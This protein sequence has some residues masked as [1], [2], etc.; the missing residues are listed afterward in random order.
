[1]SVPETAARLAG[2]NLWSSAP[3]DVAG[4]LDAAL[5]IPLR[6]RD[7]EDGRHFS[8]H[9]GQL[10]VSVHPADEPQAELA[11][12]VDEIEAAIG[13]CATHG[14]QLISGPARMP[15][16]ISA[17]LEGPGAVRIELLQTDEAD[18]HDDG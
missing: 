9:A 5:G 6:P 1:M 2:V 8:G 15:Y 10:V 18:E 12:V 13:A 16:G 14:S 11:F 7:A 3:E 4:V 17:H